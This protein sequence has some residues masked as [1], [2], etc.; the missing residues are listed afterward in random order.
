MLAGAGVLMSGGAVVC[1]GA[2]FIMSVLII[3]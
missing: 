2:K 1:C 3:K